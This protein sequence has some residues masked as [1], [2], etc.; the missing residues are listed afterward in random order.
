MFLLIYSVSLSQH[1][2]NKI[3]MRRLKNTPIKIRIEKLLLESNTALSHNEIH[4]QMEDACDKVTTYRVLERLA[5]NNILHKVIG[6]DGVYRYAYGQ[7]WSDDPI[8]NHAHFF[9]LECKGLSPNSAT[10]GSLFLVV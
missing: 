7:I 6:I 2:C 10:L 1:Y 5:N 8:H 9:C 4:L 3:T